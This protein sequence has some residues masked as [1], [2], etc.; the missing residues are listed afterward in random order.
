MLIDTSDSNVGDDGVIHT[1]IEQA[2]TLRNSLQTCLINVQ[3]FPVVLLLFP[4]NNLNAN[5]ILRNISNIHSKLFCV[6]K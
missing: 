1:Y 6:L 4:A 2:N 3:T 5:A